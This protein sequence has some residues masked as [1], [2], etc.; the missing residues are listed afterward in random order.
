ML[1]KKCSRCKTIKSL[2]FFSI[3][4]YS[5]DGKDSYCKECRSEYHKNQ[6]PRKMKQMYKDNETTQ[7]RKCEEVKENS[8]FKVYKG[9]QSTYCIECSG[10]IGRVHNLTKFG[11]TVD[12][13]I[14]MLENQNKV[15][16]IC[17]QSPVGMKKRLSVDHNH[18]CHPSGEA[19][20]KCIRKLLCHN[21]N[22][23]LG[24]IKDDINILEKM[25]DYLKEH[26]L[27]N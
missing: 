8:K 15:C 3:N 14:E 1:N 12:D 13:Y 11:L 20:N 18:N 25:I 27:P 22:T 4:K 10:H 21:C 16:Y 19:C 24:N 9:K 5:S 17:K 7:C 26:K 23:A 6:Y 2:E